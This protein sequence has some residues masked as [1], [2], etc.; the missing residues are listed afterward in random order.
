MCYLPVFIYHFWSTSNRLLLLIKTVKMVILVLTGGLL[1]DFWWFGRLTF[2]ALNFVWVNVVDEVAVLFGH[3]G[4][5][6]WYLTQGFPVIN[7]LCYPLGIL[8]FLK[9]RHL[10]IIRVMALSILGGWLFMELGQ[11]FNFSK[12]F[13]K[14]NGHR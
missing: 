14:T 4:G 11:G 5:V 9:I 12:N 10:P 7:G 6:T 8:G 1:Y 13:Q 2:S 3:M